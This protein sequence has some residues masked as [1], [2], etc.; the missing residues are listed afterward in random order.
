MPYLS[1]Q[2][3]CALVSTSFAHI[4]WTNIFPGWGIIKFIL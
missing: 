2:T 3:Y 1:I 4:T